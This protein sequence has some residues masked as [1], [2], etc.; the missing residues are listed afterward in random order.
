MPVFTIRIGPGIGMQLQ[1]CLGICLVGPDPINELLLALCV[2]DKNRRES[3][4][5]AVARQLQIHMEGFPG[6]AFKV[7]LQLHCIQT[8]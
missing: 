7:V 4:D 5:A 1:Y 6:A 2:N 3:A 8:G